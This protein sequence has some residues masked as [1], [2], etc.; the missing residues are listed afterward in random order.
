MAASLDCLDLLLVDGD[1]GF[2]ARCACSIY[3]AHT[4]ANKRFRSLADNFGLASFYWSS[5]RGLFALVNR[6]IFC[7]EPS[8]GRFFY[9]STAGLFRWDKAVAGTSN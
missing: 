6:L 5:P 1:V 2:N 3:V 8:S 9:A 4:K 7:K